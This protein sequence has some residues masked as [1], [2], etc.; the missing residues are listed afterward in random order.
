MRTI[1]FN[2]RIKVLIMLTF[3]IMDLVR[4]DKTRSCLELADKGGL[5][6][7]TPWTWTRLEVFA[8]ILE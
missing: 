5:N 1:K 7:G 3:V 4:M 2:V 6:L 8:T